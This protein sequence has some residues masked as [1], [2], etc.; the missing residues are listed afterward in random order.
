[1]YTN[2]YNYFYST[3]FDSTSNNSSTELLLASLA[4]YFLG[5]KYTRD[6]RCL[7][8]FWLHRMDSKLVRFI[9]QSMSVHKQSNIFHSVVFSISSISVPPSSSPPLLVSTQQG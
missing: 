8:L 1:M 6:D 3:V 9:A 4:T 7:I 5:H 2:Y